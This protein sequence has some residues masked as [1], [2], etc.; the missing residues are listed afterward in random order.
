[1]TGTRVPI[2]TEVLLAG[3]GVV[4]SCTELQYHPLPLMLPFKYG[5]VLGDFA[6]QQLYSPHG[7]PLRF[8]EGAAFSTDLPLRSWPMAGPGV[9]W[10]M[11]CWLGCGGASFTLVLASL[12]PATRYLHPGRCWLVPQPW[13]WGHLP[14]DLSPAPGPRDT[15]DAPVVTAGISPSPGWMQ[16]WVTCQHPSAPLHEPAVPK[17]SRVSERGGAPVPPHTPGPGSNFTSSN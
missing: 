13:Q 12:P 2:A 16:I 4:V 3:D 1:M 11:S 8:G 5:S 6:P 9:C 7:C 14:A 10:G 15:P 17:C